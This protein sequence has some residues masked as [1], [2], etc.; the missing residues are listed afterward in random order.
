MP[1]ISERI[2]IGGYTITK[3]AD[4]VTERRDYA[5]TEQRLRDG[6]LVSHYLYPTTGDPDLMTKVAWTL[7]WTLLA[8]ADQVAIARLVAATGAI[9][10]CPWTPCVEQW[11]YA[12]GDSY[13]GTLLRR[14]AL[15]YVSPLPTNAASKY[16]T[17]GELNGSTKSVTLGAVTN[18]RTAW[19]ATGT[20]SAGDVISILYYPIY[21]VKLTNEQPSYSQ[22]NAAGWTLNLEE[23]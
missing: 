3:N 22:P 4:S 13:A 19:T 1:G 17:A 10:F 15:S 21:R 2:Y 20:A 7:S 5:K 12:A 6:T 18:Y 9:D 8:D 11:T 16:A 23:V 14:A